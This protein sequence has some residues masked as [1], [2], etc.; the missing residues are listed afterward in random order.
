M[1]LE[2]A[3]VHSSAQFEA[4][5]SRWEEHGLYIYFLPPY[6]PELNLIEM[7]W[8]MI[9]YNWLPLKAYDD[10]KSLVRNLAGIFSRMRK[11]KEYRLTFNG[12]SLST[13]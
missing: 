1:V 5:I 9:K 3:S 8:R 10:F 6:C 4:N 13:T 2:N 11:N 12:P 7:L